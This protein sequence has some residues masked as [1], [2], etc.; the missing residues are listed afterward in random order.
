MVDCGL[1]GLDRVVR[2]RFI[3]DFKTRLAAPLFAVEVS[4]Y[5]E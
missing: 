4:R 3:K 2:H 1:V 5:G